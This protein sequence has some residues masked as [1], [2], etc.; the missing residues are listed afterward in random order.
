MGPA[1]LGC[2]LAHSELWFKLASGEG[3]EFH[4]AT[5]MVVLEDF[6]CTVRPATNGIINLAFDAVCVCVGTVFLKVLT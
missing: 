6:F 4:G 3:P 1:V 2:A 5:S